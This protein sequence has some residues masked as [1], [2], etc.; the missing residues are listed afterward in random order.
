M[1]SQVESSADSA[2]YRDNLSKMAILVSSDF[3]NVEVMEGREI[4]LEFTVENKS[5][6]AWPFRPFVQNEKDKSIKQHVDALLK[7]GEQTVVRYNF[8]APLQQDQAKV[9]ILLQLVE[10]K[11]Y[12]K[13]CMD[14]VIVQCNILSSQPEQEDDSMFELGFSMGVDDINNYNTQPARH[15]LNSGV[16]R[17]PLDGN[18]G[19]ADAK[20]QALIDMIDQGL[21]DYRG[22]EMYD[23]MSMDDARSM[24]E[25]LQEGGQ[26]NEEDDAIKNA[27]ALLASLKQEDQIDEAEEEAKKQEVREKMAKLG[28]MISK[29]DELRSDAA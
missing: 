4:A 14:T 16:D 15:T 12:T 20:R 19:E 8:R 6:M 23:E 22:S 17:D 11:D 28:D 7:P 26:N 25:S 24:V 13:F 29:A 18:D 21:N 1:V 9:N 5:A 27:Q 2:A 3:M 10:P